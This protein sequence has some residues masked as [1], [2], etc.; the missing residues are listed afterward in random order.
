MY[1]RE[2][3]VENMH[4]SRN[5]YMP[6]GSAWMRPY[7]EF[8]KK[9]GGI[10]GAEVSSS[11]MEET[12]NNGFYPDLT[13]AQH[14][15]L[16]MTRM[17][18]DR[19]SLRV[20]GPPSRMNYD[21]KRYIKAND[22]QSTFPSLK[23]TRALYNHSYRDPEALEFR[24]GDIIKVV[25]Q[26]E[27]GWF[28][29][30][31]GN[32]RGWFPKNYCAD[33]RIS[34]LHEDKAQNQLFIEGERTGKV[35]ALSGTM[36]PTIYV[37]SHN[38]AIPAMTTIA[39]DEM[40]SKESTPQ[41]VSRA[42]HTQE[43]RSRGRDILEY[44]PMKY[45]QFIK[46]DSRK[47]QPLDDSQSDTDSISSTYSSIFER[48]ESS[49]R[50]SNQ[51]MESTSAYGDQE[52]LAPKYNVIRP[53]VI[54]ELLTLDKKRKL[55]SR[56]P[57]I[58]AQGVLPLHAAIRSDTLISQSKTAHRLLDNNEINDLVYA[59]E[60]T[61][62]IMYQ[63]Q[64]RF[65]LFAAS[66]GVFI[67]FLHTVIIETKVPDSPLRKMHYQVSFLSSTQYGPMLNTSR[68]LGFSVRELRSI[69][70]I[71]EHFQPH[72]SPPFKANQN[73]DDAL[74]LKSTITIESD[75]PSIAVLFFAIGYVTPQWLSQFRGT[76]FPRHHR[77]ERGS[78]IK[79]LAIKDGILSELGV[80]YAQYDKSSSVDISAGLFRDQQANMLPFKMEEQTE[81]RIQSWEKEPSSS[82][83]SMLIKRRKRTKTGCLS[84]LNAWS[85]L[86]E[87]K[88][89]IQTACRKRRIKC[90]EERPTCG[91]CAK[92]KRSCEGYASRLLFKEP[93]TQ[94][95]PT[96]I[97]RNG[98]VHSGYEK[99]DSRLD[100][101]EATVLFDPGLTPKAQVRHEHENLDPIKDHEVSSAKNDL[102]KLPEKQ[103]LD[104][105]IPSPSSP[106]TDLA[107]D[108]E[109]KSS[110]STRGRKR[111][112][113]LFDLWFYALIRRIRQD[114]VVYLRPRLQ[115]GYRRL[116]WTCVSNISVSYVP[117]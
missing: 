68:G 73:K 95:Q 67:D 25:G 39:F 75:M 89:N 41:Y 46:W 61:Q 3:I 111:A 55:R 16:N 38:K 45:M 108:V 54:P 87:Q 1:N 35:K 80:Q 9:Q 33:M 78:S 8:S 99:L 63:G 79:N 103:H 57:V 36:T 62:H 106:P 4:P 51:S 12:S 91:N 29:G 100:Y 50:S 113:G 82:S 6:P 76:Y 115:P 97:A 21:H 44:L 70:W 104:S 31:I 66:C 109:V 107:P 28:D 26:S 10:V 81:R 58:G 101:E 84:M 22:I 60:R 83:R 112:V 49:N 19:E 56:F 14:D 102:Q 37:D 11:N 59:P 110:L 13:S 94:L 7:P 52:S 53:T 105:G 27:S 74:T 77:Q 34:E 5:T 65:D 71:Q 15:K 92:S 18:I 2:E 116:E 43:S 72:K 96:W 88:A 23:Y 42:R 47:N 69:A 20:S 86:F 117:K 30:I 98:I 114:C 40:S 17:S 24:K 48:A 85:I 93:I 64:D 90:T 32:R